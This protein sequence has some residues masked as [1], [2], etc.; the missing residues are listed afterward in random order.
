[1]VYVALRSS[2]SLEIASRWV[3]QMWGTTEASLLTDEIGD[4]GSERLRQLHRGVDL[5]IRP[6]ES[7]YSRSSEGT[8]QTRIASFHRD[9]PACSRLFCRFLMHR[10]LP[11]PEYLINPIDTATVLC[12]ESWP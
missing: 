5:R 1:M 9:V 2:Q 12:V 10:S 3:P 11:L 8:R 6:L 4:G 7:R